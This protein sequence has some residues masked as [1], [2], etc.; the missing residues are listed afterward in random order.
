M[1]RISFELPPTMS[2]DPACRRSTSRS[3]PTSSAR[4]ACE[5]AFWMISFM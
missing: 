1:I 4:R 5:S 2:M 3:R